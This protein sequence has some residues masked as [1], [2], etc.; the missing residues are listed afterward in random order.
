MCVERHTVK[1][2]KAALTAYVT[3]ATSMKIT[4]GAAWVRVDTQRKRQT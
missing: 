3:L 2:R 1:I 4:P